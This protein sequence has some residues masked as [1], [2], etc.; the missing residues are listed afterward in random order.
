M[1][2]NVEADVNQL[3]PHASTQVSIKNNLLGGGGG[4]QVA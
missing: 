2:F 1:K 4:R 3:H